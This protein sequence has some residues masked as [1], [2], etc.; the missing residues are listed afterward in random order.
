MWTYRTTIAARAKALKNKHIL[1]SYDKGSDKMPST[2]IIFAQ[3]HL[4]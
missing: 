1:E 2:Q 4:Q 3:I